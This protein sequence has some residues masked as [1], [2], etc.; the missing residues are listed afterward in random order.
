MKSVDSTQSEW[1]NTQKSV[2]TY[3][4]SSCL[5]IIAIRL[6]LLSLISFEQQIKFCRLHRFRYVSQHRVS[7]K[8]LR[9][10]VAIDCDPSSYLEKFQTRSNDVNVRRTMV[11]LVVSSQL[12]AS[13]MIIIP[14]LVYGLLLFH[15]WSNRCELYVGR[16]VIVC[17]CVYVWMLQRSDEYRTK[18]WVLCLCILNNSSGNH[19][20]IVYW[21]LF[22]SLPNIYIL[23]LCP[24]C[25]SAIFFVL[26][27]LL[28][29]LSLLC[30]FASYQEIL[31]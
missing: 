28:L 25:V 8:R 2:W 5:V 16:F 10:A 7:N 20:F 29:P 13:D 19:T 17:V 6:L 27:L 26:L 15:T 22:S 30:Y 11:E 3:V 23:W 21:F 1:N 31:I 14:H 9:G 12:K 18:N 4:I 24:V